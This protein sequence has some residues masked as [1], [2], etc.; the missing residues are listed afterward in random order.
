[1]GSIRCRASAALCCREQGD[2]LRHALQRGQGDPLVDR[3]DVLRNRLVGLS[4]LLVFDAPTKESEELRIAAQKSRSLL[5]IT[6]NYISYIAW[7]Q[8]ESV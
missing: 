2:C 1:M 3:M 5:F 7:K 8:P 6:F 4:C